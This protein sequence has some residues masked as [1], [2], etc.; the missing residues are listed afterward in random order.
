MRRNQSIGTTS[1]HIR[2]SIIWHAKNKFQIIWHVNNKELRTKNS[3]YIICK[4][5]QKMHKPIIRQIRI[6]GARETTGGG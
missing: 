1:V 4:F 6:E 5:I 2:I 3:S